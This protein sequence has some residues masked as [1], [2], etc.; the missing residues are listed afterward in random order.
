MDGADVGLAY[1]TRDPQG[2][3]AKHGTKEGGRGAEGGRKNTATRVR[4]AI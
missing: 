1:L 4:E 3:M 2:N